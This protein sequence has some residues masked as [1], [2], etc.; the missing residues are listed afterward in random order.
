MTSVDFHVKCE[1]YVRISIKDLNSKHAY[2][3][4]DHPEQRR[5]PGVKVASCD[6]AAGHPGKCE[7]F[8]DGE[9]GSNGEPYKGHWLTWHHRSKYD[10]LQTRYRWTSHPECCL[11]QSPT[12]W[13]CSRYAKHRGGHA[14]NIED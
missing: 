14:F 4:G 8:V 6:L 12:G 5:Y 10:E 3:F 11:A 13:Y 1:S 9:G 7:T 2:L